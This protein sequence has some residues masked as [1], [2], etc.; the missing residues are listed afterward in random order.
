MFDFPLVINP[1]SSL[2]KTWHCGWS[3]RIKREFLRISSKELTP[4]LP[5][6][7]LMLFNPAPPNLV[8]SPVCLCACAPFPPC[9]CSRCSLSLTFPLPAQSLYLPSLRDLLVC[10]KPSLILPLPKPR[11][12]IFCLSASKGKCVST[13]VLYLAK[14][15]NESK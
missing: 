13:R 11:A 2:L 7:T 10:P 6:F 8:S 4:A 12:I 3:Y 1:V 14:L 15:S 9:L 5:A